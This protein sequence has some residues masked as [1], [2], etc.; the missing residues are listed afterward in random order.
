MFYV[1]AVII[2]FLIYYLIA[3]FL[4]RPDI[5]H[6]G[7]FLFTLVAFI[8]FLFPFTLWEFAFSLHRTK[9]DIYYSHLWFI[10]LLILE[11]IMYLFVFP[12]KLV[13]FIHVVSFLPAIGMIFILY[14]LSKGV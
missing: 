8:T 12:F 5:S 13:V 10:L 3:Y 11:G 9:G 7:V 1:K 4:K 14:K 6:L 2:V